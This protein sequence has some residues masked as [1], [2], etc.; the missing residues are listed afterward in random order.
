MDNPRAIIYAN[1]HFQ[2]SP[3]YS[4]RSGDLV[5]AADGGARHCQALGILPQVILGDFDSLAPAELEAFD[6]SGAIL[7]RSPSR[8][9]ET[10]LE[11]AFR[12]AVQQGVTEIVVFGGLGARW[13]M[14]V[15]NLLLA[16]APEY[17]HLKVCFLDG[18]QELTL[19]CG[20]QV[21]DLSGQPGDIVSLI[22]LAGD[23]V[24]V[25][26]QGLEYPLEIDTLSFASP[27]GVS[28]VLLFP[29]AR[30]SLA[31]GLLLCV[32]IHQASHDVK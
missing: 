19:L 20:G 21:L 24:G 11:L 23:A 29:A 5:I 26:T 32:H 8:K 28:N 4:P 30:V 25:T 6:Q 7:V 27:R 10:D 18:F 14:T 2:P 17:H 3:C 13:D 16:S 15:A 31:Q 1:G 12:Y 22:P 9:D